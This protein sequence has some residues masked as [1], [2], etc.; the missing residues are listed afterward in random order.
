MSLRRLSLPIDLLIILFTGSSFIGYAVSY[1]QSL[2][3]ILI[4]VLAG[5]LLYLLIAHMGHSRE[6]GRYI[7][8]GLVGIGGLFA[9]LFIS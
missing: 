8:M 7:S 4:A 3:R 5:G 6:Y 2:S 1:D 9:L